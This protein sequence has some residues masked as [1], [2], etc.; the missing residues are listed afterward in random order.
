MRISATKERALECALTREG[1]GQHVSGRVC[2]GRDV[3]K[4]EGTSVSRCGL[5]AA[6]VHR[7]VKGSTVSAETGAFVVTS[8]KSCLSPPR[9]CHCSEGESIYS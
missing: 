9:S 1:K 6:G 3:W 2:H 4:I 8:S 5:E 7:K